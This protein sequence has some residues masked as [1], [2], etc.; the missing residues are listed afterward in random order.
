MTSY[1]LSFILSAL[2][3]LFLTPLVQRLAPRIGAVDSPSEERKVHERPIP[4]IGGVAVAIAFFVPVIGLFFVDTTISRAYLEDLNH[5]VGLFLGSAL[6]VALGLAD[7]IRGLS[8]RTKFVAQVL[9]ALLAY[10]LGYRIVGIANPLGASL[11]FGVFSLPVTVLWIVGVTNAINLIDGLDGLASGV[12]LV[13]VLILF[14]LGLVNHNLVVA[15][16]ASALA[17]AL[18]GFL[19]YNFNPATI[20]M[21]DSGSLFLGY[22][23]SIT[24]IS[25]AAKSSTVVSLLIPLLALGLPIAETL[26]T[27]VRRFIGGRPIFGA[28]RGHLHHRLL[29]RGLS[30]RQVVLVLYGGSG[31]V[32][33][34]ALSLVYANDVQTAYILGTLAAAALTL[35]YVTGLVTWSGLTRGVRYGLLRQKNL[36]SHLF[37]VEQTAQKLREA[38]SVDD[39][40]ATLSALARDVDMDSFSCAVALTDRAGV[41][42]YSASWPEVP[43]PPGTEVLKLDFP[44]DWTLRDVAISGLVSF[45]WDCGP[46]KLQVPE[47]G[48]Y[49]WIAMVFRDRLLELLELERREPS[50]PRL[51]SVP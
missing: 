43:A 32:G 4:R 46:D 42:R 7:D 38:P 9:I 13:T 2:V 48:S 34:I 33:L 50:E 11:M 18:V 12:S 36:R 1:T 3:C 31:V 23:L 22:V 25:G 49:D 8:A 24:A 16:T 27:I 14:T 47:A 51:A 37:K 35:S 6:M 28:D 21:G 40:I 19:K 41:A 10:G 45:V 17:G 39:A 26:S 5:V 29:D 44:L 20:F 15:L 30:H